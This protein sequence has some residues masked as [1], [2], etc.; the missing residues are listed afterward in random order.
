MPDF[1][2]HPHLP[3]LHHLADVDLTVRG[4]ELAEWTTERKVCLL[5]P[6]LAAEFEKE[7]LPRMLKQIA[8]VPYIHEVL[9][10][11]NGTT[12]E[13]LKA[14]K[15]LVARSLKGKPCHILWND[16]PQL[17]ELRR[18]LEA[19]GLPAGRGPTFGPVCC[20]SS[21]GAAMPSW[22]V[23]IRTSSAT[24]GECSGAWPIP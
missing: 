4:R 19:H 1:Y 17:Q 7:A 9:L 13:Q 18:S 10:S 3:T 20:I 15:E 12:A 21:L 24:S 2:Q 16:G 14:A 22:P 5:L 6:A 11:I 23:T 8:E